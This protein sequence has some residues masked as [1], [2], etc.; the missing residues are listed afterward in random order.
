MSADIKS[1]EESKLLAICCVGRIPAFHMR[2]KSE[3]QTILFLIVKKSKEIK[4]FANFSELFKSCIKMEGKKIAKNSPNL[5]PFFYLF[6]P[7]INLSTQ[8]VEKKNV[9]NSE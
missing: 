4:F 6:C 9:T 5:A 3:K 1:R 2:L 8:K 7:L